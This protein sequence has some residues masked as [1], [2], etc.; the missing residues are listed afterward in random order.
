ML[1]PR[2]FIQLTTPQYL[3]IA[4]ITPLSAFMIISQSIPSAVIAPVIMALSFAIL[5]FNAMNA[6]FDLEV[7]KIN[8]PLRPLPS[9]KMSI[10]EAARISTI[11]FLLALVTASF[12]NDYFFTLILIFILVCTLYSSPLAY[13]RK[14]LWGST[15]IGVIL[16]GII[17]FMSAMSISSST[18]P[19]VPFLFFVTL[20]GIVSNV[21]DFE[22]VV[23]EK[24]MGIDSLPISLGTEKASYVILLLLFS[25]MLSMMV[26]EINFNGGRFLTGA[27]VSSLILLPF[28]ILFLNYINKRLTKEKGRIVTQ[29]WLVT[30]TFV[31]VL[32]M[33]LM[34]GL[35]S[36]V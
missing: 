32:A 26:I 27:M 23:G 7:D 6:I 4:L 5:G 21:K 29:S 9:G 25:L 15:F 24:K 19:V 22:D 13:F 16:Y 8:K 17:P 34:F 14:Y 30:L 31:F 28:L 3:M 1:T 12:V 35:F 10:K 36:L 2:N 18:L 11:L 20:A 33:Q